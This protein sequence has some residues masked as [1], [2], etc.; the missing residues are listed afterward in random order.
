MIHRISAQC[1]SPGSGSYLSVGRAPGAKPAS[2]SH[3]RV[4]VTGVV[5][6]MSPLGYSISVVIFHCMGLVD[7][8]SGGGSARNGS[9]TVATPSNASSVNAHAVSV[10][11]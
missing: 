2:K 6:R 10:P 3:R 11:P 4:S 8:P 9:P 1:P 5:S 7:V